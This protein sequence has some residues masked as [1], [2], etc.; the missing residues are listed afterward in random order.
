M[1]SCVGEPGYAAKLREHFK[2][3]GEMI[4]EFPQLAEESMFFFVPGPTDPGS[5]NIFPRPPLPSHVTQDLSKNLPNV[6]FLSNP[7]RV[8]YCTQEI[9]IFREDIVTKLCRN[10]IYF[11]ETGEIPSHFAKTITCQGHRPPCPYTPAPCSGTMTD[12]S[13]YTLSL[14]SL[15]R[16]I[17]LNPSLLRTWAAKS[18]TLGLLPSTTSPS[19]PTFPVAGQWRT[20]KFLMRINMIQTY[21]MN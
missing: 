6:Q 5:P 18:S 16:L 3:L 20:A 17:S 1:G 15:S 14:T 7:A 19:R 9:V 12:H 8:Q 13:P 2:M 10:S 21:H 4:A 11:P